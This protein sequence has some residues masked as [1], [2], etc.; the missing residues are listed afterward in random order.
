MMAGQE[1]G[2]LAGGGLEQRFVVPERIVGVERDQVEHARRARVYRARRLR[3]AVTM[4]D[5]A[6]RACPFTITSTA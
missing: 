2:E 6:R 3:A 1:G 5:P 4:K